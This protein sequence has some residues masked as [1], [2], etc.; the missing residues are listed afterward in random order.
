[1]KARIRFTNIVSNFTYN[2][3]RRG[4]TCDEDWREGKEKVLFHPYV[5]F[6]KELPN[7]WQGGVEFD[8]EGT[9][10]SMVH[11]HGG[12]TFDKLKSEFPDEP[13]IPLTNIPDL[14]AFNKCRV[15]GFDTLHANDTREFW[16]IER[17]KEE[18]LN[19]M[20]QIEAL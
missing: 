6:D 11:V 16:T 4:Y 12:I 13:I 10:D 20:K 9:L 8:E 15:I 3:D 7:S 18:T 5:A 2:S 14:E 19:L 1:M 17:I